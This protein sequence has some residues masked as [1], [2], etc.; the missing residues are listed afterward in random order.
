MDILTYKGVMI[1]AD[2]KGPDGQLISNR[3]KFD[4]YNEVLISNNDCS[5]LESKLGRDAENTMARMI[6]SQTGSPSEEQVQKANYELHKIMDRLFA[7][8]LYAL[9][10]K[11]EVAKGLPDNRL[12][13][14]EGLSDSEI[15]TLHFEGCGAT[16]TKLRNHR[17]IM[18]P[19]YFNENSWAQ[20]YSEM[21]VH[22]EMEPDGTHWVIDF[23]SLHSNIPE[24]FWANVMAY[25]YKLKVI[26]G[27]LFVCWV[28]DDI[29]PQA[30]PELM[31]EF[32]RLK[33][34]G[35]YHFSTIM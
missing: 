27:K 33:Q 13:G 9:S 2:G 26:S 12:L 19:E 32:L 22:Y 29:L 20:F 8:S 34:I 5:V 35:K 31:C 15:G 1:T 10:Y 16:H 18:L 24:N 14:L 3:S 4:D 28:H 30:N 11:S 7:V 21:L 23:S 25:S 6:H 17:L